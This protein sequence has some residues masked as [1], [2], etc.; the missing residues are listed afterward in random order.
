MKKQTNK[1]K[2]RKSMLPGELLRKLSCKAAVRDFPGIQRFRL[3][4][5]SA[6]GAG[7]VPG[8]G[9]KIL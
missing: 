1:K 3:C 9:T 8:Q 6:G 2:W 5:S 7:L 4:T